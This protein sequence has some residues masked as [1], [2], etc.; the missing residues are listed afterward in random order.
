MR[1]SERALHRE[2]GVLI[3]NLDSKVKAA[4]S[5]QERD[6]AARARD[7]R[8]MEGKRVGTGA[9]IDDVEGMDGS[10]TE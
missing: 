1:G 4:A 5:E 10:G 3:C 8:R 9:A 2:V 6:I 7:L